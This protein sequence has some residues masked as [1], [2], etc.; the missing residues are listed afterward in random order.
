MQSSMWLECMLV[1]VSIPSTSGGEWP[2]GWLAA[3]CRSSST[4]CKS[5]GHLI[6]ESDVTIRSR[7]RGE[8]D[9]T[10]FS[11]STVELGI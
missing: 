11:T 7:C 10:C 1:I 2:G 5:K 3:R 8:G 6:S 9:E 4:N